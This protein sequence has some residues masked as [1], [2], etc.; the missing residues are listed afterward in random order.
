MN[1]KKFIFFKF[2]K[3]KKAIKYSNKIKIPVILM[4][5][6]KAV[7]KDKIKIFEIKFFLS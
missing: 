5:I 2:N 3:I 7:K 6:R 1:L 4:L